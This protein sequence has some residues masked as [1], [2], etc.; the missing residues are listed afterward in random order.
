MCICVF[1]CLY[2]LHIW[3]NIYIGGFILLTMLVFCT[4]THTYYCIFVYSFLFSIIL[5]I[6]Y[7]I[8]TFIVTLHGGYVTCPNSH[9]ES[10]KARTSNKVS[11]FIAKSSFH[12]NSCQWL[13]GRL[14][15]ETDLTSL[16]LR[17]IDSY[18]NIS[19]AVIFQVSW[20]RAVLS[21]IEINCLFG[22]V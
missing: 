10:G 17:I 7:L 15:E 12:Y 11:W 4:Y 13:L 18:W 8:P 5:L 22:H 1:I 16:K 21:I 20:S 6:D 19:S 2:S 3:A 14:G 9:L